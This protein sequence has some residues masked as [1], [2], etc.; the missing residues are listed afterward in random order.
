VNGDCDQLFELNLA[1]NPIV[2]TFLEEEICVG[3]VLN[4]E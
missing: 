2:E 4:W 3:G 1:V